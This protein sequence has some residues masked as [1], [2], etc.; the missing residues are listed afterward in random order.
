[1]SPPVS[2]SQNC[3]RIVDRKRTHKPILSLCM[4]V[5]NEESYLDG[6]IN[7]VADVVDEIIVVDTG[8]TDQTVRIAQ[9]FGAIVFHFTW[10]DHF[11]SAR[12]ESIKH[13]TGDWILYLDADERLAGE[14][15]DELIRWLHN[16]D[17][18]YVNVI[19]ASPNSNSTGHLS[20][21]HRL[22]RNLPGIQFTG[23]IHEQISPS[24]MKLGYNEHFS[25]IRIEHL[26]YHKSPVKM[27]QKNRRNV[28]LL[29][30]QIADDPRNF[31]WHYC[32][33]QNLML[34]GKFERAITSL[35][36]ALQ[37]GEVPNDIR[38]SVYNNLAEAHL[39]LSNYALAIQCARR[40]ISVS[41]EQATSHLLLFQIYERLND[42][43]AQIKSLESA[44]RLIDRRRS[45]CR[46]TSL[47]AYV[48]PF[49]VYLKIA[50]LYFEKDD[51][52][53]AQNYYAKVLDK[54]KN[55]FLALQG[56]AACFL[57]SGDFTQAYEI[58]NRLI[59]LGSNDVA[60][61][62]KFAWLAIKLGKH[63][64]AMESYLQ[65]LKL[66]P[67]N[68]QVKKRLAALYSKSGQIDQAQK[69]LSEIHSES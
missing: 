68:I 10:S 35:D 39:K 22:F 64:E 56:L 18:A 30:K 36:T 48:D 43:Q 17:A 5:R 61:L 38:C 37:L 20:R 66:Q 47:E 9:Q 45:H 27:A 40:A 32:L 63:D 41:E 16:P 69:I 6:C 54:N 50:N 23:R 34:W 33:A 2:V 8:S 25:S 53:K 4:I 15:K 1:M 14:S 58:L 60:A 44:I 7:S 28:R 67:A 24:F 11:S 57:K 42:K 31:Y 49:L 55:N 51:V 59:T 12:N 19:I 13:A 29:K 52:E 21:S 46:A 65:L 26:G 3:L 62:D